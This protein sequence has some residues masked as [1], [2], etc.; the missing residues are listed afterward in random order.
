MGLKPYDLER[1]QPV[2]EC[3]VGS[4]AAPS[5]AVFARAR[6]A[7]WNVTNFRFCFLFLVS[8]S[9]SPI[10]KVEALFRQCPLPTKVEGGNYSHLS[11]VSQ[12][13]GC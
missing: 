10:T 13:S 11:G 1:T 12:S 5:R 8:D 9:S 7:R 6:G 4:W 3:M 2:A